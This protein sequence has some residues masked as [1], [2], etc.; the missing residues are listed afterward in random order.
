MIKVL[1]AAEAPDIAEGRRDKLSREAYAELKRG[2]LAFTLPPGQR[3]SEAALAEMLAISRTPLR[4]ALH[5]LE[6]E[7]YLRNIGGHNCWQIRELDLSYYEDLYD[8]RAELEALAIRMA[9]RA[10]SPPRLDALAELWCVAIA[11][12]CLDGDFVADQDEKFHLTLVGLARNTSML[13]TFSDITDRIRIIRRVDFFSDRRICAT[14][15]EHQ[16]ILKTLMERDYVSGE[17]LIRQHIDR[18]RDEIRRI[19]IDRLHRNRGGR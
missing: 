13:R 11:D 3:Y 17:R 16:G 18:S 4:L 10:G 9:E 19:T 6:H 12:R 7:G 14:Y 15:D 2:I 1:S 8:F 5:I